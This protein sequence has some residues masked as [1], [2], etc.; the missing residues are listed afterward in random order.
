MAYR[1]SGTE[2][3]QG[4]TP[5]VGFIFAPSSNSNIFPFF[6]MT[7]LVYQG[8]IPGRD[9]DVTALGLAYGEFSGA[10]RRVGRDNHHIGGAGLGWR[11]FEMMLELTYEFALTP[12]LTVQ[13]DAQYIIAPSGTSDI[14]DALV[15]GLQV[16]VNF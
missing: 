15:L 6:F 1:E 9:R 11:G 10:L 4:L 7:G 12:W 5:F 2:S 16:S 3:S 14:P 13:P 8:L